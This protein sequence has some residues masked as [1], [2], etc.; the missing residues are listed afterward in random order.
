MS[1]LI[2]VFS[3]DLE[4]SNN[5]MIYSPQETTAPKHIGELKQ[6]A[7]TSAGPDLFVRLGIVTGIVL[8]ELIVFSVWLDGAA[9][10]KEGGPAGLIGDWI[11]PGVRVGVTFTAF[12]L[13]FGFL[14]AGDKWKRLS[15]ETSGHRVSYGL[16][17]AHGL[18]LIVLGILS[19]LLF[20]A[21]GMRS[22][23][24]TVP[25]FVTG[26][27]TVALAGCAVIPLRIWAK[28]VRLTGSLWIVAMAAGISATALGGPASRLW[29]PSA[30]LT[31]RCVGMLLRPL[32][33]DFTADPVNRTIG[34]PGFM[35]QI[36][37]ACSGLEGAGLMLIFGVLWLWFS[38]KEY[39]FSRAFVLIPAGILVLWWANVFRIAALILIGNAGAP[40]LAAGGF[41]SQA[42]W[43]AFNIVAIG[44][45][46][47]ARQFAGTSETT[48]FQDNAAAPWLMPLLAI[49]AAGM[50]SR[51]L[52]SGFEWLYPLRFLLAACVLWIFRERYKSLDWH[53]GWWAP[54]AG[55]S[56]FVFWIGLARFSGG[57]E[58]NVIATG[59]AP[60]SNPA[61]FVWLAFRAIA[62]ITTV[63]VSE[64][65][66]FRG[67]LI[68]R[69]ISSDF[70]ALR[71]TAF[72]WLSLLLS[73]L[74]FG[75]MHGDRWIAGTLAGLI[76]AAVF[77]QRGRIGD[78][79]AAHVT[80]N[81][82]LAA[83]VLLGAHWELW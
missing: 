59:L 52:T 12:L 51:A 42:G 55:A 73:S 83:W 72:T 56:V 17:L 81:A 47:A 45:C 6:S 24:V 61:K 18:S 70:E 75:F 39:R 29:E 5:R 14:N 50:I 3:G 63:P 44:F 19:R 2:G 30:Q 1:C 64:E 27:C 31:F 10:R 41:H 68:R 53:F 62:A 21:R 9:L 71:P 25:W 43:I 46:F 33:T 77:L 4:L 80:T 40:G 8:L 58:S 74:A 13:T 67:F 15:V 82:L 48:K 57:H 11:S 60:L 79:V 28:L 26:L 36:A 65:L 49:L 54:L 16:L 66:A 78:A 22:A 34:T 38:R 37:D 20:D 35:V 69:L 32:L 23:S 7:G 76:Y